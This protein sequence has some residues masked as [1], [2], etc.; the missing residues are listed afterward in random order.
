MITFSNSLLTRERG[1]Q[2]TRA[3]F[4]FTPYAVPG[5]PCALNG[6]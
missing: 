1:T 2:S 3:M 5:C 6:Q 4:Y